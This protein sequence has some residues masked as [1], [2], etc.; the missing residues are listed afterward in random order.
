VTGRSRRTAATTRTGRPATVP[1]PT[2][3]RAF[4]LA[5]LLVLALVLGPGAAIGPSPAAAQPAD[6]PWIRI[7]DQTTFVPADGVLH[8][9]L[10]V[11]VPSSG[12]ATGDSAGGPEL[13][14]T[15]FGRL[16]SEAAVSLPP[17]QPINRM[18]SVPLDQAPRTA[19]GRVDLAI[20]IRSSTSFDDQDR[21]LLREPGVYPVTVELRG[22]DG[23]LAV[24]RTHLVRQPI[25]TADVPTTAPVEVAMILNVATAEGL[26]VADATAL[27]ADHP[28]VPMTVVLG[29]GV[30][31][32]LRGD[33]AA[34]E[35][36]TVALADRTVVTAPTID[37]D[38]SAMAEIDQTDL[39]LAAARSDRQA[40]VDLGLRPAD[41][42]ALVSSSL[43]E[44]GV[45][46]LR[47]LD[48]D[49]VLDAGDHLGGSGTIAGDE[50]RPIQVIAADH[51]LDEVLSDDDPTAPEAGAVRASRALARL[52]LRQQTDDG[53]VVIGGPDLA[54]DPR[55]ALDAFLRS[56][57]QPGAPQPVAL[58]RVRGG[59]TLRLAETPQQDLMPSAELVDRI[60]VT[61]DAYRS[62]HAGGGTLPDDY[63]QRLAATLAVQRNP[64]DRLRALTL[65]VGQLQAELGVIHIHQPQPVT[66]AAR[67]ATIPLV[68]D[69]AAPGPRR[70]VLRFRGDRVVADDAR[71]EI[72]VQPGTNSLDIEV[73]ARSLGV[74]PLE[75]TVWSG[76]E[77]VL[78]AEARFEI[79]STAVPGLGLLISLS[80]LAMLGLWWIVD[81]RR[82]RRA[83]LPPAPDRVEGEETPEREPTTV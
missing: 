36:F 66:L 12:S 50:T 59:P 9:V 57:S 22:P 23:P 25:E 10:D 45:D 63:L 37:L 46:V 43:T 76:D 81:H 39:Y 56:L 1:L 62:S 35:A 80:A 64:D 5:P 72:L 51:D 31:S 79:R 6:E 38:P 18:A 21:V 11:N 28:S 83:P 17:T 65:L 68:M 30:L 32:Q 70:V 15:F 78:L 77:T 82:R 13:S 48:V 58:D 52:T 55:P 4:P 26:T 8:L 61:L 47:R 7:V 3:T 49:A 2:H 27:L 20:P 53:V 74:S 41:G 69:N 73:E 40:V 54:V 29:Q 34:T 16:E 75:A 24:T 33:P 42:L 19:A 71:R 60:R 14:V 44:R 67:S